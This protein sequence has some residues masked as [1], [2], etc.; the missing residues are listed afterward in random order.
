MTKALTTVVA[1]LLTL[2]QGMASAQ[3]ASPQA[4]PAQEAAP[5]AAPVAAP[6]PTPPPAPKKTKLSEGTEFIIRFNERLSSATNKA[7][8]T[9]TISLDDDVRLTDGTMIRAGY[10]GRGEV[11][12]ANKRGFMGKAGELNV[13]FDYIRIGDQRVRVRATKGSEGK[14]ALGATVALTVIF[15][16]LGLLKRGH[17]IEIASGQTLVAYADNDYELDL[18]IAPPPQD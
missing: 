15:G 4:A 18:P 3:D 5:A 9:F 14:G 16:P 17:D 10:R 7:G 13:R 8:D 2:C 6:A 12:D 1:A 11:T